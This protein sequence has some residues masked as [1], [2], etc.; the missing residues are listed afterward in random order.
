MDD[1]DSAW[2]SRVTEVHISIFT[3]QH[4]LRTAYSTYDYRGKWV[5]IY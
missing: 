3:Q 4:K 1:Y 5:A 2:Q